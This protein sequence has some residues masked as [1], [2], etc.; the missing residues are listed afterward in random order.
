[1]FTS[2][3]NASNILD[4]TPGTQLPHNYIMII[5]VHWYNFVFAKKGCPCT[6]VCIA[7]TCSCAREMH[8]RSTTFRYILHKLY[9]K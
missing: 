9:D 6:G 2:D 7:K 5:L 8:E 4:F 1:M 3:L